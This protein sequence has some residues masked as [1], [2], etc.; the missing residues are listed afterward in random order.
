VL[1]NPLGQIFAFEYTVT[2]SWTDPK[3]AKATR[4]GAENTTP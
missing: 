1:K 3:V 4:T 2:G